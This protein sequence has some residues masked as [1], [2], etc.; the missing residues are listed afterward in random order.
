MGESGSA[1][2]QAGLREEDRVVELDGDNIENKSHKKL[3]KKIKEKL[4]VSLLVVDK[5]CD[6]WFAKQ[7]KKISSKSCDVVIVRSKDE[8]LD[9]DHED[10]FDKITVEVVEVIKN[11]PDNVVTEDENDV[12][13]NCGEVLE[14]DLN[15]SVSTSSLHS[16]EKVYSS[17]EDANESATDLNE[18]KKTEE[19]ILDLPK[20]VQEMKEM[21]KLRKKSDP[22]RENSLDL[23]QKHSIVQ[24]L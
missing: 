8:L 16:D 9:K 2:H 22:R 12:C 7:R 15:K 21:I 1:A 18:T 6:D 17:E 3:V 23:W 10:M 20:T 13:S 19:L 14:E 11:V 5:E 24:A 4:E